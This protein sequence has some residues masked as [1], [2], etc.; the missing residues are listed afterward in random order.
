MSLFQS[1][2]IGAGKEEYD[3]AEGHRAGG[4]GRF[5]ENEPVIVERQAAF[6]GFSARADPEECARFLFQIEGKVFGAHGGGRKDLHFILSEKPRCRCFRHADQFIR[7]DHRAA[8]G[9]DLY[10]G[11]YAERR[12]RPFRDAPEA[13]MDLRAHRRKQVSHGAF[14][15][16][17]GWNDVGRRAGQVCAPKMASASSRNP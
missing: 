6:R 16:D 5:I 12:P 10:R 8:A 7:A 4:D 3:P 2:Q 11:L 14:Q 1:R 15:H 9:N 13:V 17:F